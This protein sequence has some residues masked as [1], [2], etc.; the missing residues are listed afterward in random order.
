[1][2]TERIIAPLSVTSSFLIPTPSA[3]TPSALISCCVLGTTPVIGCL[4]SMRA[5]PTAS[6]VV[7]ARQPLLTE[8]ADSF[9]YFVQR[10]LLGNSILAVY[11]IGEVAYPVYFYIV[12]IRFKAGLL[13]AS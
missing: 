1:M 13:S 7:L 3:L 4:T 10:P 12:I 11:G 2:T 8:L 9:R 6:M 5:S